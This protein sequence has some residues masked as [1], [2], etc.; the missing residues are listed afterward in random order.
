MNR[1]TRKDVNKLIRAPLDYALLMEKDQ[2][3]EVIAT[4]VAVL[5]KASGG[6]QNSR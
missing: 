2:L 5:N 4:L 6:D 1:I 3:Q